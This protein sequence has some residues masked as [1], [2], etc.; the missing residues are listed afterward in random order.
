MKKMLLEPLT[1]RRA[2]LAGML[3]LAAAFLGW[4]GWTLYGR[5]S[6][7]PLTVPQM[8]RAIWKAV[9]KQVRTKNL[10]PPFDAAEVEILGATTTTTTNRAG[11][12][13]TVSR[14]SRSALDLPETTVSEYFRTN[15][16]QATSYEAM[17]RFLGEQLKVTDALFKEPDASKRLA[18]M[19]MAGEASIYA[20]TN[21]HDGGLSARICEAYLWPHLSLVEA[22]NRAPVTAEAVLNICDIAF[23]EAGETNNIIRN[24]EMLMAR[25]QRPQ[26]LDAARFRLALI[27]IDQG[28]NAKALKLLKSITTIKTAKITREIARLE[29]LVPASEK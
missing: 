16:A 14:T 27:Y 6:G 3:L 1:K 22:S 19:V 4:G 10:Q 23:K 12:V 13:R 15:Q 7:R 20:R 21:A 29:M 2:A 26:S 25:T 18:G 8:K 28:E 24:Y 11:R 9:E 17:Y 5:W